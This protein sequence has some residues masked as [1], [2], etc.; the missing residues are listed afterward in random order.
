MARPLKPQ[1][2]YVTNGWYLDI[3]VNGIGTNGLFETLEGISMSSGVV[4]IVD[5]GTNRKFK[6]GDQMTDF[7]ELTLTR[8]YNGTAADRALE[9]LVKDMIQTGL[10]VPVKAIKMHHGE[11]VLTI[12][13]DGFAFQSATYPSFDV[14]GTDKF[15]VSYTAHCDGWSIIPAGV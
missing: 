14:N 9:Q 12:V 1:D 7:G 2:V 15:M 4:E 8:P 5:A 3:P 13:F 6:F 10:K 11:E